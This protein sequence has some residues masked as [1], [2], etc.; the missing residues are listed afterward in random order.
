MGARFDRNRELNRI[1]NFTKILR[2]TIGPVISVLVRQASLGGGDATHSEMQ[3]EKQKPLTD[4]LQV[5]VLS[6]RVGRSPEAS[7]AWYGSDPGCEA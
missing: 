7:L 3:V 1:L 6:G 2:S 5:Q 4:I